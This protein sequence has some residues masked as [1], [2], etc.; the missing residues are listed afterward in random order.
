MSVRYRDLTEEQKAKV[1][2]GCGPKGGLVPVPEFFCHA[3]CD[4]HDFNYWLGC[5]EADRQKADWEFYTEMRKDAGKNPWKQTVA[6]AYFIAVRTCGAVCFHYAD[7]ER[8]EED[9]KKAMGG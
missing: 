4:H 8:D 5:K 1:C 9:L 2:N 6:F 3:S 7:K